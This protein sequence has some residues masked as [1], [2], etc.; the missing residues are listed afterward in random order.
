MAD[1]S[2][3]VVASV[4]LLLLSGLPACLLGSPKAGQKIAAAISSIAAASGI[5]SAVML[6]LS[7]K[8]VAWELSWGI[9]FGPA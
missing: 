3:I 1:P 8:T 6:M 2:N 4:L 9:P 5:S 7:H